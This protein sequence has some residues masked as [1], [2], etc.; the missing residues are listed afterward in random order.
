M[1]QWEGEILSHKTSLFTQPPTAIF[2]HRER[3]RASMINDDE[4]KLEQIWVNLRVLSICNISVR[5]GRDEKTSEEM[6]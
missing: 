6:Q 1:M 3:A 5:W 2:T 4:P